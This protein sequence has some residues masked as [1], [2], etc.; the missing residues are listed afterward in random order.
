MEARG[1]RELAGLPARLG[2][3]ELRGVLG[4]GGMG[5]VVRAHDPVL[6]REVAIKLVEP[7]V[8]D[9]A[10]L[11]ELRFMFHRE[12]RATAALCH[13]NIV[14]VIDYSGPEAELPYLVCE[15]VPGESLC[16]ILE[17]G[18]LAPPVAAACGY[19]LAQALAHAHAQGIVHRDL[20]P[21]NVL[22]SAAG[23]LVLADFGI[24]KAL[25]G[26]LRLGGTVRFGAT[27]LYGS[28]AYMAP[29]QLSG[30]VEPRSDLFA[31]GALLFECLTGEQAF[32]GEDMQAV[33]EAV[34][35]GRR[36][37][38]PA[39]TSLPHELTRL[40]DLL[41][42]AET[43][44]RP[45][46]ALALC[47]SLRGVLDGLGCGDPRRLLA[48]YGS[49]APRQASPSR[50][51]TRR[52]GGPALWPLAVATAL[53]GAG[54]TAGLLLLVSAGER[55]E[56]PGAAPKATTARAR[57]SCGPAEEAELW[58]DERRVGPC[59]EELEVDLV[60][61]RHRLARRSPSGESAQEVL[62]IAGSRPRFTL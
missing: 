22:W 56:A 28:P 61:G 12:A 46:S 29:E 59:G 18:P 26:S 6:R 37:P 53:L 35:S 14:Q 51:R 5:R 1:E 52:A 4:R 48:D 21:E 15:L 40:V 42:A 43:G 10:D 54:V 7:S 19:E 31:L 13:P 30:K 57:I 25:G 33:L 50:G 34:Q 45:P 55:G 8:V 32:S 23:R 27:S 44:R 38:W 16:Q 3:Y 62:V 58:I 49:R 9:A 36:T 17:R 60:A 2:R 41:L 47:D 24:A 20:K 11:A 39:P